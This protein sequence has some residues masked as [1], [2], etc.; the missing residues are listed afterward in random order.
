MVLIVNP[1]RF[2][3]SKYVLSELATVGKI[4]IAPEEPVQP[5]PDPIMENIQ[6]DTAVQDLGMLK[7]DGMSGSGFKVQ[8][9]SGFK[10]Q[11]GKMQP[12]NERLRKFISLKLN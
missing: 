6:K 10:V 1:K 11:G 8:G 4:D 9:G 2:Y 3:S 12:Q 5:Q 7:D